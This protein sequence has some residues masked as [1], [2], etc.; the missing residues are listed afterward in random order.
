MNTSARNAVAFSRKKFP[1][2]IQVVGHDH[3]IKFTLDLPILYCPKPHGPKTA[4]RRSCCMVLVL[5][6][7]TAVLSFLISSLSV[8][9]PKKD[10]LC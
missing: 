6:L 9:I 5:C 4:F 2:E 1:F 8:L 7:V 10:A 3:L